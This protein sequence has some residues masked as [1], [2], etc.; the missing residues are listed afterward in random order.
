MSIFDTKRINRDSNDN[1]I[2]VGAPHNKHCNQMASSLNP[3]YAHTVYNN[4]FSE[5]RNKVGSW[6]DGPSMQ[7]AITSDPT[8]K[9]ITQNHYGNISNKDM[10]HKGYIAHLLHTMLGRLHPNHQPSDKSIITPQDLMSGKHPFSTGLDIADFMNIMG[11]DNT[12]ALSSRTVK[13]YIE[14]TEDWE[15]LKTLLDV[16]RHLDSNDPHTIEEYLNQT[17]FPHHDEGFG[18]KINELKEFLEKIR[19]DIV[20]EKEERAKTSTASGRFWGDVNTTDAIKEALMFGGMKP[21]L[22]KER[23]LQ[24]QLETLEQIIQRSQQFMGPEETQELIVERDKLESQLL[25]MQDKV[26]GQTKVFDNNTYKRIPHGRQLNTK[27]GEDRKLIM[28]AF[29]EK[30]KPVIEADFPDAFNPENPNWIPNISRAIL[31]TQRWLMAV[32]HEV[33]G[34]TGYNYGIGFSVK[35]SPTRNLEG[36][37]HGE[38][39]SLVFSD[40]HEIDG[41]MSI[42]EVMEKLG[43]QHSE[44]GHLGRMKEHVRELI[45]KSTEWNTPIMVNTLNNLIANSGLSRL[46][47]KDISH[48]IPDE[49]L[50][51]RPE[52]EL[53]RDDLLMRTLHENGY[54]SALELG[55]KTGDKTWKL[56]SLHNIPKHMKLLMNEKINGDALKQNGLSMLSNDIYMAEGDGVGIKKRPTRRTQNL[57]DSIIIVDPRQLD[58][59]T[60]FTTPEESTIAEASWSHGRPIGA[61]APNITSI[62]DTWDAGRVDG[63]YQDMMVSDFGVEFGPNGEPIV[64]PHTEPTP[65]YTIPKDLL[66][67]SFPKEIVEQALANAKPVQGMPAMARADEFGN[68]PADDWR[69]VTTSEITPL[70]NSLL[71]PDMLLSKSSDAEWVPPIRPMHRIFDLDN[72]EH[73]RGFT[74]SWVVSKWY[75]GKRVVIVKDKDVTVYDENGKKIGVKKNIRESLDK[76]S[77]NNYTIDGILGD[78]ELNIIDIMNYDD[79]NISDM[80]IHERLKVLRGQLDSHENVIIP[81]P[82][83]TRFTDEEGLIDAVNNLQEEHDEILLRDTKSTYMQGERRH[84][85]WLILRKTKDYNFIVLD[86]RGKGP[87]TYQLGAGPIIDGEGL[88]NRAV[89]INGKTY[90]DVG[91]AYREKK[92]FNI[93]DIVRVSVSGISKKNRGKREIFNVQV[94]NIEGEGEGEGAASTESLDLLTKSLMPIIIPHDIEYNDGVFSVI[95]KDIATVNYDVTKIHNSVF[96]LHNPNTELIDM[97]KS[98]YPIILA[99]SLRPFWSP[100]SP[101]LIEGHLKKFADTDSKQPTREE[102]EEESAGILEEDDENR[103]LKPN[104]KKGLEIIERALDILT[105]ERMTWTGAKGLG[106]DMATP[107]ESP[108]GP[109]SLRDEST[110][111]DYD[112]RPRPGEELEKP[113]K[114]DKKPLQNIKNEAESNELPEEKEIPVFTL[115]PDKV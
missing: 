36:D 10:E 46:G 58:A 112:N 94:S 73:L 110:L 39:S 104:T 91:T 40:G 2:D 11:W 44:S 23:E 4:S 56:H 103:L 95:L 19:S 72:L 54:H 20:K 30:I 32:P 48:F 87:Y 66:H 8:N 31:D 49:E 100:L 68:V 27:I 61:P 99:E 60:A 51:N 111:P 113:Y 24:S 74:G 57:L 18:N 55:Q 102:Q 17:S 90:M 62:T 76:L 1:L 12:P 9:I 35:Q 22:E 88:G 107:I 50:L 81:G 69:T 106:I 77:D 28:R 79:N 25:S 52:D 109:T 16:Q 33:H 53:S 26:V 93:G 67:M 75:T 115:P 59:D 7:R 89:E 21:S 92:I 13:R 34:Y 97:Y 78:E 65:Y 83:D 84:P 98:N 85:K 71:N 43:L 29:N 5:M 101:L 96:Y 64:G 3:E 80:H 86:R 15:Q 37:P 70:I 41:N 82:H 114:R 45:D 108:R 47:G 38:L 105:K 6:I 14:N 42:D 63:A